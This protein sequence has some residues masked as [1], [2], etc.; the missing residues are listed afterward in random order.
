MKLKDAV[1]SRRILYTASSFAKEDLL[2]LQETGSLT[3]L[4]KHTSSRDTLS[5]YLFIIVEEGNGLLEYC[6]E[7]YELNTGDCVFIDCEKGYAHTNISLWSLKW[8]HF[9]GKA[10]PG[11]YA[12]YEERGG[13]AVFRP[14]NVSAISKLTDDIYRMAESEDYI[15]D[16]R[17]NELLASLLTHIMAESWAPENQNKGKR[18]IN[19]VRAYLETNYKDRISLDE[20]EKTFFINKYYLTRLFKAQYGTTI[21]GYLLS[22]KISEAKKLL[23]FSDKSVETIAGD[24]GFEDANYFSRAFK[25]IEGVSPQEYRKMW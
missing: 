1:N 14:D 11:I 19:N 22:L 16:M 13:R 24:T 8:V 3:A 12:K 4:K 21:V 15:R 17:L 9:Y 7:T 25:K 2:F 6:G 20:L 5:S 18:N 10:M 23:R